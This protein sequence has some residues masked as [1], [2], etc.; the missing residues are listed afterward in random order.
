MAHGPSGVGFDGDGGHDGHGHFGLADGLGGHMSSFGCSF[1]GHGHDGLVTHE[2]I[3]VAHSFSDHSSHVNVDS[4]VDIGHAH[5]GGHGLMSAIGTAFDGA[6]DPSKEAFGLVLVGHDYIDTR[7]VVVNI[8]RSLGLMELYTPQGSR[9]RIDQYYTDI[10]PMMA[11]KGGE[12]AVMPDG[13]YEGATGMTTQWRSFWQL[14]KQDFIDKLCGRP[15]QLNSRVRWNIDISITQW[16]FAESDDYETRVLANVW[17]GDHMGATAEHRAA[18]MEAAR[19]FVKQMALALSIRPPSAR[20]R[21]YRAQ[22]LAAQQRV[23][24]ELAVPAF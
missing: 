2:A 20:S 12:A 18:H 17:N 8:L 19:A 24:N 22:L 6:I 23:A 10:M 1:D 21:Q 14:G 7:S 5:F 9:K 16:Y 13:Y 15:L 4:T 3:V 11:A